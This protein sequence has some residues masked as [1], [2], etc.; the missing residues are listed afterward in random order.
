MIEVDPNLETN[1]M[2]WHMSGTINK[3]E[4]INAIDQTYDVFK[5][6][7]EVKVLQID[8]NSEIRIKPLDH[9]KLALYAKKFFKNY[10]IIKSAFVFNKPINVAY[11]FIVL[12][13]LLGKKFK[14]KVFSDLSSAQEWL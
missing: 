5:N 3:D 2:T 8:N 7:E 4:I 6:R 14:A 10:K 13:T 1:I 11:A 9:V 12:D